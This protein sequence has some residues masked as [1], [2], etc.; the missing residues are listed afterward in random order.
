MPAMAAQKTDVA[1]YWNGRPCGDGL[2]EAQRGS[3]EYFEQIERAKDELEPYVHAF[4]DFSRWR[5]RDVLEIG[6]GLGTDT[7]RFARAGAHVTAVDLSATSVELA[8]RRLED[9]GLVGDIREAD[10]E[11]LPFADASF[12]LVYSW[13]VLHHTPDTARAI[14][15]AA[16]V[17]RPDGEARLMLYNSRSFFAAGVWAR[18]ALR[19]RRPASL[20]RSLAE[21]LESPGTKAYTRAELAEL[22]A[23]FAHTEV[24]T[25]ATPYDR[26]VAGP[27]AGLFGGLGWNHLIRATVA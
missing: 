3:A 14:R 7:V 20:R 27:L 25:I 8:R 22:L 11:Q 15:E 12:D 4:A 1:G 21:G 18:H 23:P 16:R 19:A 2:A 13:G 10:A 26:R 24:Q 9:S 5:D 6:C 17:L